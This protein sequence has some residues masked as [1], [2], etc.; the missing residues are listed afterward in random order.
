VTRGSV[1]APRRRS[2]NTSNCVELRHTL[3]A[4]RDSKRRDGPTLAVR[5]LPTFINHI[6]TGQ[7]H[8]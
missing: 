7:F 4:V 3:D 6:K 2:T 1:S 8:R 5:A